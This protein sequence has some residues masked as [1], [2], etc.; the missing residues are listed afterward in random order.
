[1]G[2]ELTGKTFLTISLKYNQR[3]D[4]FFD[5]LTKAIYEI[6]Y[7]KSLY[8]NLDKFIEEIPR[9][10]SIINRNLL[11]RNLFEMLLKKH[12]IEF[13]GYNNAD[14]FY[15]ILDKLENSLL[16][17]LQ[18]SIPKSMDI[19]VIKLP[20]VVIKVFPG[21]MMD[22]NNKEE[23][24]NFV[25]DVNGRVLYVF[26]P[27]N[28]YSGGN[29]LLSFRNDNYLKVIDFLESEIIY[30]SEINY[31]VT[32]VDE[33][34]PLSFFRNII[35]SFEIPFSSL[36]SLGIKNIF[37]A[38]NDFLNKY[39]IRLPSDIDPKELKK[40]KLKEIIKEILMKIISSNKENSLDSI[41]E[42]NL[43]IAL[44]KSLTNLE[45]PITPQDIK[46]LICK[47]YEIL[48][49]VDFTYRRL[50]RG[51]GSVIYV[52]SFDDSYKRIYSL[53]KRTKGGLLI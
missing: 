30:R 45:Y 40:G 26:S 18:T 15:S 11:A 2:P 48:N 17:F 31:V 36:Q 6:S 1:M 4:L 43:E 39:N 27:S 24:S 5:S 16:S 38:R 9:L 20:R 25:K 21:S 10:R 46:Y 19:E 35:Y 50:R 12:R 44:S 28:I 7:V 53:A 33:V 29:L 23:V 37:D 8:Q 32:M 14:N 47:T 42:K 51:I 22:M 41:L 13:V 3:I 34:D 49:L 52:S